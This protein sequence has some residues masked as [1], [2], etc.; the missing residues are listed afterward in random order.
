MALDVCYTLNQFCAPLPETYGDFK[1][2]ATTFLPNIIDTKV[3]GQCFGS[4]SGIRCLVD[5]WIRDPE[6]VKNRVRI[7]DEQPGSYF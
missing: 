5:P 7:R 2:M 6:W 4:G 3:C 1:A